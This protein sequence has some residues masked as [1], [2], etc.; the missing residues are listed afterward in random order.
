M[1]PALAA[2]RKMRAARQAYLTAKSNPEATYVEK[3]TAAEAYSAS[4]SELAGAL[5]KQQIHKSRFHGLPIEVEYRRGEVRHG[6][7]RNGKRWK[8]RMQCDYGFI[9]RT[10]GA[11]GEELDFFLGSDWGS[12]KVFAINQIDQLTG[13]YDET[14]LMLGFSNEAAA[15]ATYLK[16]YP[17]GWR[18]GGVVEKDIDWLWSWMTSSDSKFLVKWRTQNGWDEQNVS[19]HPVGSGKGGQFAPKPGGKVETDPHVSQLT[20]S[21]SIGKVTGQFPTKFLQETTAA[22][23][24]IRKNYP[25]LKIQE[26]VLV[27]NPGMSGMGMVGNRLEVYGN[28]LTDP[29][30]GP[31]N[32]R[33]AE[34]SNQDYLA[35]TKKQIADYDVALAQ[36]TDP[37]KQRML[38]ASKENYSKA[39]Q[40]IAAGAASK[41]PLGFVGDD[42]ESTVIHETGHIAKGQLDSEF[43]D[44]EMEYGISRDGVFNNTEVLKSALR[45]SHYAASSFEEYVAESWCAFNTGRTDLLDGY[46][47]KIVTLM[48][49]KL[50]YK[51]S[52]SGVYQHT[53]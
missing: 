42:I 14:K 16:H 36:E 43:M 12:K 37:K 27:S 44:I 24:K 31:E 6:K 8:R 4:Q 3:S 40:L 49:E 51:A 2:I 19:R 26:M 32:E 20:S 1:N 15:I 52:R 30:Y 34:M 13:Q 7:D 23:D 53:P 10:K 50:R 22:M 21:G 38:A 46:S 9:K 18:I 39:S 17:P 47:T 33:V 25:Q 35:A 5:K 28:V 29:E 48:D 45:L 11:D 41:P